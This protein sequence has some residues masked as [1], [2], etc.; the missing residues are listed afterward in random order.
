MFSRRGRGLVED[1]TRDMRLL[2][3][4]AGFSQRYAWFIVLGWVLVAAVGNVLVPQ[5]D[6]VAKQYAPAFMASQA[7]TVIAAE[8]AARAFGAPPSN[9]FVY[10]VLERDQPLGP[11]DRHYYD[12][13]VGALRADREHVYSVTDLWT[14]NGVSAAQSQDGEAVYLML[15]L[16]GSLGT[17]ASSA[18]VDAVR[19]TVTQNAPPGGLNVYVTGPGATLSDEFNAVGE[20]LL[21]ITAATVLLITVL[22]L[23]VYR[24]LV[25]AAIPLMS[26]GLTLA[27]ARALISALGMHDVI[28]VSLFT[29]ALLAAIILGLGTDYGIFLLG[30]YHECRRRGIDPAVALS[31]AYRTV[32]KVIIGSAL[33]IAAALACLNLAHISMFRSIGISCAIGVLISAVSALTLTPA[34]IAVASRRGLLEPRRTPNR[35][36]R[37]VGIMVARWPG[38]LFVVSTMLLVALALPLIGIKTTWNEPA[39]TPPGTES[40]RG[41]AAIDKHF[42]P[43]ELFPDVVTIEADHDLRN[44]AGLIAIERISRQIMAIPGVRKVQSAS[45]PGG[46]IPD[47]AT[48]TNQA[49]LIG[50]QLNEAINALSERLSRAVGNLGGTL[51][52]VGIALD[53]MRSQMSAGAAGMQGITSAADDMRA[54]IDGLQSNITL[55]SGYLDP[56]RGFAN[57]T[58]DC[59]LNPICRTVRKVIDP[60]D[61]IVANANELASGTADL[62]SGANT[63]S[64][65]LAGVPEALQSMRTGLSQAQSAAS[66]LREAVAPLSSQLR[67]LTDYLNQVQADFRDGAAG[68]FYAPS[69]ALADPRYSDAL[70]ALLSP[71]GHAA[72]LLVYSKGE[73]WGA[74]GADRATQIQLA[75]EEATKEGTLTPKSVEQLGVGPTTRDMQ[76]LFR[77]DVVM[78]AVAAL[79]LIFVIVALTVGSPVAA[80]VIVGTVMVSYA[81]ALGLSVLVWQYLLGQP[82][83]WIVAPLSTIALVGVGTDYNLLLALRIRDEARGGLRTGLIRSF[84]GTGGIVTTAGLV[85]GITMFAMAGS[86]VLS[87]TQLGTTIGIGLLLDTLVVRTFMMPALVVLLGRWFWWPTVVTAPR[88]R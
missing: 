77:A 31:D 70:D 6:V 84:A 67:G 79:L 13:L 66:G 43:N 18:A 49:G 26:V 62:T 56:L 34:L 52:Q 59:P 58:P 87:V 71:D 38:P 24:S 36:W 88:L 61:G 21:I 76:T 53:Q 14:P 55:V 60:V 86:T 42:P 39:S 75:V 20:Q 80:L 1:S 9:N 10:V 15:R 68:G 72:L 46:T 4:G 8:Q 28:P 48:F 11:A 19:H 50:D 23:I 37:R 47:E 85:F 83:H 29:V 25:T 33:I 74:E 2:R 27:V 73:E 40:N 82:L 17:S 51:D 32:G 78:L 63:S 57:N 22:L 5:L 41:Y 16:S 35:R 65:A 81:S 54:G 69:R 3:V 44:P 64:A 7:P 30:R 45:R 12:D